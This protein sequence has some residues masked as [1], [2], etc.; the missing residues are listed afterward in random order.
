[1]ALGPYFLGTVSGGKKPYQDH[2]SAKLFSGAGIGTPVT[3]T[4]GVDLTGGGLVWLKRLDAYASNLLYWN[5]PTD[6]D[7][8]YGA[9][10][11][12]NYPSQFNPDYGP[13]TSLTFTQSGIEFPNG[14]ANGSSYI[15]LTFKQRSNFLEVIK[16][17]GDGQA[18]RAIPH[19]LGH[20]PSTIITYGVSAASAAVWNIGM[21]HL[22]TNV[23]YLHLMNTA[24][25]SNYNTYGNQ[26]P[27][28]SVYY[29]GY[30]SNRGGALNNT[31]KVY[32]S[33]VF[34]N[35]TTSSGRVA[36]GQYTGL[37]P[38]TDVP[39][40]LGWQPRFV[41][42]YGITTPSGLRLVDTTS[43]PGFVGDETIITNSGN[44]PLILP[45]VSLISNGFQV[46]GDSG[47]VV[48]T[49]QY[50]YFAVR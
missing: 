30:D 6:F 13:V 2:F 26:E 3:V 44:V 41:F 5:D 28:D 4:T 22:S 16:Y 46:D 29:V 18:I 21:D 31:G 27:T 38:G 24:V 32:F 17:T 36:G 34:A 45:F 11:D 9:A 33:F 1:M 40:S 50:G 42:Q 49:R 19:N 15:V 10:V 7:S 23:P 39:L 35:D 48:N 47:Q 37:G 20:K 14:F 25:N 8:Y 12:S 43:T